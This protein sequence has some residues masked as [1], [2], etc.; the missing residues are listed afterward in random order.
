MPFAPTRDTISVFQAVH[1]T[2]NLEKIAQCSAYRKCRNVRDPWR[3]GFTDGTSRKEHACQCGRHMQRGFD[4][5]VGE[6]PLEE[7]MEIHSSILAWKIPS[8]E[9]PGR[10]QSMGSQRVEH[11]W[12]DLA[13]HQHPSS[14]TLGRSLWLLC[15][16]SGLLACPCPC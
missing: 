13:S 4:S 16:G 3:F 2:N 6:D 7:D 14:N 12:S 9:E 8:T 1:Y 10:L 11:N 5:W 15:L